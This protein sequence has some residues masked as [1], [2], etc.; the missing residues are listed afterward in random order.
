[1]ISRT[2]LLRAAVLLTAALTVASG[3]VRT[4]EPVPAVTAPSALDIGANEVQP[5]SAP[6]GNEQYGRVLESVRMAEALLDPAEVDAALSKGV[7]K[8][9]GP[10]PNP[11]KAVGVLAVPVQK[12]LESHTMLAGYVVTGSEVE[13]QERAVGTVR[14]LTVLLLR[15]PDASA[16]QLAARQIDATDA[17]VNP[18]N[19]AVRIADYP[20]AYGHWRP[21]APTMAATLAHGSFVISV[22]AGHTTPDYAVLS[23]LV[24]KAFDVQLPRLREFRATPRERFADLPLDP[25]GM[26]SRLL[27]YGNGQWPVPSV[28]VV[29]LDD[30][31]GLGA[32]I[33]T[34]GVVYGPRGTRLLRTMGISESVEMLAMNGFNVLERFPDAV[35]ARRVV[36]AER[37]RAEAD[38]RSAAAPKGLSDAY[39]HKYNVSAPEWPVQFGCHVLFGRY[40]ATIVGRNLTEAQQRA[41]AQY[42]LLVNSA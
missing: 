20:G 9:T 38:S 5:L 34:S 26:V 10:L 32:T 39:C 23:G 41:A 22:L 42:L 27:P 16:A 14:L 1:M 12:V 11:Q 28:V 31:A 17:A 33:S 30:Q 21:T 8:R 24:R 6:A 15:F 37:Q 25:D 7:A 36:T 40:S 2:A 3:C 19:V 4:G 13:I 35:T 18:D 29:D